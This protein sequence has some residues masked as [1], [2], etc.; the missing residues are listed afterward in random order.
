MSVGY[1]AMY[2]TSDSGN[3]PD[4]TPA[5]WKV[6]LPDGSE[7]NTSGS[8]TQ[9]L[10]EAINY[11]AQYAFN[12]QVYGGG[13]KPQ[14][15]G[16]NYGGAL[17][18]NPFTTAAGSSTVTVSQPGHGLST[19]TKM[20]FFGVP[21]SVN[22]IPGS[23]FA[24]EHPITVINANSYAITLSSSASS[25][26]VSG[27]SAVRYQQAGQDA[28]II[29]CSTGL[30]FPPLQGIKID[31]SA[32]LNFGGGGGMPALAFDSM[33]L[34]NINIKGQIVCSSGY[35]AGVQVKPTRELPQDP[36]GPVVTSTY[37][38]LPSVIVA[39]A[40][41][42]VDFDATVAPIMQNYFDIM[43]PNNT[44]AGGIGVRVV[45]TN[46]EGSTFNGN[47]LR[48]VDAHGC[49]T[50][51]AIGTSTTGASNINGNTWTINTDPRTGGTGLETYGNYDYIN[52]S[53]TSLEGTPSKGVRILGNAAGNTMNVL[54]NDAVTRYE[55][56]TNLNNAIIDGV[57]AVSAYRA[58][59]SYQN[60]PSS[61]WTKVDFSAEEW[62]TQGHYDAANARFVVSTPGLYRVDA[63]VTFDT[64]VDTA[65]MQIA[66]H[67]SGSVIK[68]H[69]TT[70]VGGGAG[71]PSVSVSCIVPCGIG[72]Y[73][74]TYARQ[75]TGSERNIA[76]EKYLSYMQIQRIST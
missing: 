37:L 25:S 64:T 75:A 48:V 62:D 36:A 58:N 8:S 31:I 53:V 76:G 22:G 44:A 66:V 14:V 54:R 41:P 9:G 2:R 10:Q 74:E 46:G 45:V 56:A 63:Q 43:E 50:G 73:L 23:Q 19:G 39:S 61:T 55:G 28:S 6:I 4:V 3:D 33:M 71:F 51:I 1:V 52:V 24:A 70:G 69:N 26:G 30:V 13:I 15:F 20:Q 35:T 65:I 47:I 72:E 32:T 67:K 49:D 42:C 59:E 17:G 16:I 57:D 11:A 60:I 38:Y 27:G 34:S 29:N 5:T 40:V 21:G 7:L 12:L 18:T 68:R